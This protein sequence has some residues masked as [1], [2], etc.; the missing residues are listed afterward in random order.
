MTNIAQGIYLTTSSM[1]NCF[2]LFIFR[3]QMPHLV[4]QLLVAKL[5]ILFCLGLTYSHLFLYDSSHHAP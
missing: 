4:D 5:Y 3:E 1:S 2:I